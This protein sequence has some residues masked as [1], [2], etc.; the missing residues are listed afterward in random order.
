VSRDGAEVT[1][2]DRSF[3]VLAPATRKTRRPT[4][5]S[6]TA[7]TS[8]S[9]DEEVFVTYNN[10]FTSLHLI[11]IQFQTLE[12]RIMFPINLKFLWL[13]ISSTKIVGTEKKD[14]T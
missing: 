8:R 10:F 2:T 3:H 11:V 9:S 13:S 14:G 6:L 1:S 12:S 5:G 4:V 7:G